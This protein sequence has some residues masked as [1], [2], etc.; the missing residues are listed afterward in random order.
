MPLYVMPLA[1]PIPVMV[2]DVRA[3][4]SMPVLPESSATR[5]L[6]PLPPV[7]TRGALIAAST[8]PEAGSLLPASAIKSPVPPR[9]VVTPLIDC[10]SMVSVPVPA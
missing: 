7:T 4:V 8:P 1:M 10:T 2:S 5:E 9:S 6:T 3:P